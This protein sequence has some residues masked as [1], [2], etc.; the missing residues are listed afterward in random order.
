[1]RPTVYPR[2]SI[3]AYT[4]TTSSGEG[5]FSRGVVRAGRGAAPAGLPSQ[6]GLRAAPEPPPGATRSPRQKLAETC[7]CAQLGQCSC[8]AKRGSTKK[9]AD[10][11]KNKEKRGPALETLLIGAPRGARRDLRKDS[12][13]PLQVALL[14]APPPHPEESPKA[15]LEG[16]GPLGQASR[17]L[18]PAGGSRLPFFPPPPHFCARQVRENAIFSRGRDALRPQCAGNASPMTPFPS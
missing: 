2:C 15:C 13:T 17:A 12:R 3:L 11:A 5:A 1:M 16:W 9:R 6:G 18:P 10:S 8:S 7:S 14:G 4:L